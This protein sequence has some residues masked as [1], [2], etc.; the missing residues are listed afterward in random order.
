MLLLPSLRVSLLGE[1][2]IPWEDTP[3]TK[4]ISSQGNKEGERADRSATNKPTGNCT[5]IDHP[6]F[7]LSDFK[8]LAV[9]W[10]FLSPGRGR[11]LPAQQSVLGFAT[12]AAGP[13]LPV[14][15]GYWKGTL[16]LAQSFSL[17]LNNNS[18]TRTPSTAPRLWQGGL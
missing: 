8:F 18:G 6:A 3:G 11:V 7:I 1:I 13:Q 14:P 15:C 12:S 9:N 16:Q 5:S 4:L 10:P 2:I 17:Q